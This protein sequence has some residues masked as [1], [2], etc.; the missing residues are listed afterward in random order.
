MSKRWVYSMLRHRGG[1]RKRTDN[2]A[3]QEEESLLPQQHA[4]AEVREG[5]HARESDDIA[6]D[7]TVIKAGWLLKQGSRNN[8]PHSGKYLVQLLDAFRG[9]GKPH[10]RQKCTATSLLTR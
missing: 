5:E 9:A 3:K 8:A 4:A 7:S 1:G 2:G 10:D 6:L